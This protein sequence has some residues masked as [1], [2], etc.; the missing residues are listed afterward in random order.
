MID[1]DTCDSTAKCAFAVASRV[2][3]DVT[4]TIAGIDEIGKHTSRLQIISPRTYLLCTFLCLMYKI[5]LSTLLLSSH[6]ILKGPVVR[7]TKSKVIM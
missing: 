3:E 2:L 1:C 5:S 7:E 6:E 4:L